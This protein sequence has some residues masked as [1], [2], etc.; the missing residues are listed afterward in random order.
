LLNLLERSTLSVARAGVTT[1][2]NG[3]DGS[4]AILPVAAGDINAS[5]RAYT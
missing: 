2:Y 4:R 1:G 5:V 3:E